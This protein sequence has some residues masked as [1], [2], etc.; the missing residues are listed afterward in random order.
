MGAAN[1]AIRQIR[2]AQIEQM[3]VLERQRDQQRRRERQLLDE[4]KRQRDERRRRTRLLQ[5]ELERQRDE[6]RRRERRLRD[7][8]GMQALL[9]HKANKA[10]NEECQ[11]LA[12]AKEAGAGRRAS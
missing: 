2:L 1:E 3:G 11:R 9:R 7:E 5:D 4:L 8:Q 12:R 10:Q 6:W